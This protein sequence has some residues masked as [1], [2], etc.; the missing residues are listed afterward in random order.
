MRSR[1]IAL[2]RVSGAAAFMLLP[3]AGFAALTTVSTPEPATMGL[4]G[5]G[6]AAAAMARRRKK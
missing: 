3:A 4:L 2:V 5:L 1:I 6:L